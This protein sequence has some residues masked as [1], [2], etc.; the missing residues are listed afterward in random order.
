MHQLSLKPVNAL[1]DYVTICDLDGIPVISVRHPLAEAAISLHGGHLIGYKPTGNDDIIWLSEKAEFNTAKAIRGGIPVCWPWFGKVANPSHGFARTSLWTLDEHRENDE[2]VIVSLTLQDSEASRD[3]WPNK[4]KNQLLFK[5]GKTLS[6]ELITTNTDDK[7]WDYSGALHSYFQVDAIQ[8]TAITGMGPS[9]IDSLQNGDTFE[10]GETLRFDS[11]TDRVYTQPEN[12]IV[13]ADGQ[14]QLTVENS[15]D[16]CAV[17]WNPWVELSTA[18][19]DMA[20][21]SYETMVC[22]ESTISGETVTLAP[23]ES[24]TLATNVSAS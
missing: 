3:I 16:N 1:S 15:G 4:F 2:G 8:N 20:D 18:M 11:E 21:N 24:H 5:I 14:R 12:A 7:S 10:G 22:V 13:I 23:G 17:I 19:G 6:V 9:Y